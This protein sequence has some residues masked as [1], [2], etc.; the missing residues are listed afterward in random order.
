VTEAVLETPQ[1]E[2]LRIL[3]V[4]GRPAT[5][6]EIAAA[7]ALPLAAIR[8][9]L[10]RLVRA[11]VLSE[12]RRG[13]S[14]LYQIAG[15]SNSGSLV[16]VP[17][18]DV[19]RIHFRMVRYLSRISAP[20]DGRVSL[21]RHLL[22]LGKLREGRR[23]A[24]EAAARLRG[25]GLLDG[26]VRLLTEFSAREPDR[27]WRLRLLA[28]ASS[29]LEQAGDHAEGVSLLEPVYRS[30]LEPRDSAEAVRLR[31]RLGVHYHRAGFAEPARKL[32]A[33]VRAIADPRR[34]LEE[35]IFVDS[36]LAELHTLRGEYAEAEAAC[37][38][39]LDLLAG[40]RGSRREF[41]CRMEVTLRASLGHLHLRRLALDRAAKEFATAARLSRTF[42]TTTLRALILNN[43]GIVHDQRNSFPRACACFRGA[44]R[45]LLRSGERRIG[46]PVAC[47][48]ATI[49]AKTG[50]AASARECLERA[51]RWLAHYP[52][53]R[54]EFQ[55]TLAR[56]MVAHFL[57]HMA[58]AAEAFERALPMGRELGDAQFVGFAEV[59][60]AEA[61][62]ACGR[63][64]EA[65]DRLQSLVARPGWPL[66]A[67]LERMARTRLFFLETLLGRRR[68]AARSRAALA[69]ATRSGIP[70]LEAWN[71]LFL[72]F[73]GILDAAG[74]EGGVSAAGREVDR[75]LAGAAR[76]FR[77]FGVPAGW[78]FARIGHLYQALYRTETQD[79]RKLLQE[80]DAAP[81]S[82]HKVLSVL[83]PLAGAEAF[84]ALGETESARACLD[85]AGQAI[86]GLPLLEL[87]WRIESLR[88]LLAER[89]GDRDGA[90]RFLHRSLHT[91]DLLV[92]TLLPAGR[93]AFLSHPRF[94]GIQGQVTRLQSPRITPVPPDRAA[95]EFHGMIGRSLLMSEVFKTIGRVRD[96]EIPVLITGE[97]GTGKELVAR[98]I[99][100]T[101]PRRR[102][103]FFALHCASLPGELFESEVFG[104][105]AGAF[106]GADEPRAGLLEHLSGGTLLLDEVTSLAPATQMKFLRVLDSGV[107]RPLG[108]LDT[109]PIDVR[110][111]ASTSDSIEK[112]IADG[113]LRRDLYF[114]LRGVEIHLPPLRSRK[115]DI[116]LLVEHFLKL[117]ARRLERA[118]PLATPEVLRF[119][120]GHDWPGNV[121]EL[122]TTLLRILMTSSPGSPLA[123]EALRPLIPRA[124]SH[125]IFSEDALS[126]RDLKSLRRE[127]DRVYLTRLFRDTRGDV[128]KMTETLGVKASRLYAWLREAGVDIQSLRREL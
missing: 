55:V 107:V 96:Q 89:E 19:R 44:E 77:R 43:L 46:I 102:G 47:N 125:P 2:V 127:L 81:D 106:T 70:L 24:L 128:R 6:D 18:R 11:E 124:P 121:R 5:R 21:A 38:R 39:G 25:E 53:K 61:R 35:L 91:R 52:G 101:S 99:H 27:T 69:A 116:P 54:L 86:V 17:A 109:R 28:E 88:A 122:E 97:T 98:A 118:P 64:R 120:A 66:P 57:G 105:E 83:E 67:V 45:L 82:G 93:K 92:R 90:R 32:F 9:D 40:S 110:F 22:A 72:A 62:L 95:G 65:L 60:L 100:Q 29:I 71:D 80:I 42:G 74:G 23:V 112:A 20:L 115:E 75:L 103:P 87:D 113:V 16:P 31:R 111:L 48:L 4:L 85:E 8:K 30:G 68:A 7:A 117:H 94:V 36:E 59:Y 126:G 104:H 84:I 50:D 26:A 41:R 12:H 51:T 73:A 76:T 58:L 49:A 108:S 123:M 3:S 10:R 13:R 114:R 119:L 56:G 15:E 63:Y 33:E 78:R 37:R 79:V 34:D 14:R 1:G